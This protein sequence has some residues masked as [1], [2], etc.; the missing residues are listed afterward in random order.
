M[1]ILS[2]ILLSCG[3]VPQALCFHLLWNSLQYGGQL[4]AKCSWLYQSCQLPV[5]RASPVRTIV[6]EEM[7]PPAV[8]R[9]CLYARF[10]CS[11]PRSH[12]MFLPGLPLVLM[13]RHHFRQCAPRSVSNADASPISRTLSAS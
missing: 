11:I 13:K 2:V 8:A 5:E 1:E 12:G 3:G 9:C 6:E 4:A 7:F 10:Q